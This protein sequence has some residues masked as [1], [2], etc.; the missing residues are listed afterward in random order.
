MNLGS[1]LI[2]KTENHLKKKILRDKADAKNRSSF[3]L[4]Q[5]LC[6]FWT[7]YGAI[8]FWATKFHV[9]LT[10]NTYIN[11]LEKFSPKWL[12]KKLNRFNWPH[13]YPKCNVFSRQMQIIGYIID[14]KFFQNFPT[15][16]SY[17]A[18]FLASDSGLASHD[19]NFLRL[20]RFEN[21]D[22]VKAVFE[23]DLASN[24]VFL[25]LLRGNFKNSNS[26]EIH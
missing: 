24:K 14:E 11:T 6:V 1:F 23:V 8:S 18:D 7:D 26:S 20:R 3:F 22:R 16:S 19:K 25:F 17:A 4:K 21:F 12:L 13:F 10:S 15:H 5:F 2:E 9:T